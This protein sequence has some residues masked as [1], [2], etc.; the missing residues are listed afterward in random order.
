MP[1]PPLEVQN[2]IVEILDKFTELEKELVARRKQYEY[3][4]NKLLSKEELEKRARKYF[5]EISALPQYD[6]SPCDS[7]PCKESQNIES[8]KGSVTNSSQPY[9]IPHF[10]FSQKNLI[11]S[12][13]A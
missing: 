6:N 9:K 5:A 13:C 11:P 8:L 3:Y 4:R 12:L 1:L 2:A 7:K 10:S